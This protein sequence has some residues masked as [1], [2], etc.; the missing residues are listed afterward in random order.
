MAKGQR[1]LTLTETLHTKLT[2]CWEGNSEKLSK[3]YGVSSFTRYAQRLI[4]SGL[5]E[6]LVETRFEI[7]NSEDEI[8]IRDY[9]L[10]KDALVRLDAQGPYARLY[11]E[12]DRTGRCPHVG[13][14]LSDPDVLKAAKER[15]ITLRKSPKSVSV[16]E[17]AEDL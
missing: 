11:C 15:G 2:K 5:K 16:E 3:K 1:S 8:R 7:V 10:S 13:F 12:L 4:E 17:A 9:L 6:D 14:M